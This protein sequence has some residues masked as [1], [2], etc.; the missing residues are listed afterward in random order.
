MKSHI[1]IFYVLFVVVLLCFSSNAFSA[2]KYNDFQTGISSLTRS[3]VGMTNL[4]YTPKTSKVIVDGIIHSHTKKEWQISK[5]IEQEIIKFLAQKTEFIVFERN[6][7]DAL[8]DERKL[9]IS[10]VKIGSSINADF[11]ITGSYFITEDSYLE[12]NL[13]L[14]KIANK[15]I[16]RAGTIKVNINSIDSILDKEIEES[17]IINLQEAIERQ[18]NEID[19][20]RR[21]SHTKSYKK[22]L[23]TIV[24]QQREYISKLHEE[25][26]N[27]K[28]RYT[29]RK[30]DENL[31][32]INIESGV[33]NHDIYINGKWVGVTP[34]I[35]YEI[36]AG[37]DHEITVR[38]DQ[39][40]FLPKT[41]TRKYQKFQRSHEQIVLQRGRATAIILSR[42]RIKD[43]SVNGEPI[44]LNPDS[45]YIEIEAGVNNFQVLDDNG[46]SEFSEEMWIG[47][48][49]RIDI[50]DGDYYT[51]Y[52]ENITGFFS[53]LG[54][55]YSSYLGY[56]PII[57]LNAYATLTFGG[58]TQQIVGL[59]LGVYKNIYLILET[60][61]FSQGE[62]AGGYDEAR[63]SG[64]FINKGFSYHI[65]NDSDE[66]ISIDFIQ[67]EMQTVEYQ[68][69]SVWDKEKSP[70]GMLLIFKYT[71]ID[72]SVGLEYGAGFG[73]DLFVFSLGIKMSLF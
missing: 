35:K 7:L 39:K 15:Q 6:Q 14:I 4:E 63:A 67:R 30:Y 43:I 32:F 45:A 2:E 60:G 65:D 56:K 50:D 61:N 3:L 46:Q 16:V 41:V 62:L 12:I 31:A 1:K 24:Q 26:R 34:L 9:M 17:S 54:D 13:K 20:L 18:N 59:Q 58:N 22:R 10:G 51:N 25:S 55:G 19:E 73:E 38:G 8:E 28:I 52:T 5:S 21:Q 11:L 70:D 57:F 66:L 48:R 47:D 29:S 72:D 27:D 33:P 44:Y 53:D 64:T 71:D 36:E 42:F 69:E 23:Q 49:L 37:K 40:F 68:K